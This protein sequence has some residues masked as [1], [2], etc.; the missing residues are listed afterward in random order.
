MMQRPLIIGITGGIGGGKTTFSTSLREHGQLVFDTDVEAKKLQEEDEEVIKGIKSLFGNDIYENNRL[1]RK[2]V[3]ELVFSNREML[4]ELNGI[5]HPKVKE[6]F[7][8]WVKVNSDKKNLFMECAVLYEG[9]FNLLVDKVLVITAP[10]EIRVERVMK[11]DG[12]T[13]EQVR[14]RMRNQFP[15]EEKI[16]YST[17]VI[18]TDNEKKTDEK[19]I[20]FLKKIAIG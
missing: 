13:E 6:K 12:Q 18:E 17:W 9:R 16:K 15:E 20:E 4:K 5:I 10:E 19:V 11:R 7:Q 2:R 1:N 8:E 14:A 3:A